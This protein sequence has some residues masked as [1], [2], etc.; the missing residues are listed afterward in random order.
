MSCVVID[1]GGGRTAIAC[2]RGRSPR[3]RCWSC[4][5]PASWLCDWPTE[6]AKSCSRPLCESC[7]HRAGPLDYCG[8]HK[9]ERDARAHLAP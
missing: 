8:Q 1:I 4:G 2:A 9:A 5:A 7:R 3:Q 6:K